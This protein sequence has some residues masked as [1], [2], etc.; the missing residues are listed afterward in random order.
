LIAQ[1]GRGES[2]A[3]SGGENGWTGSAGRTGHNF[4]LDRLMF[5]I[6]RNSEKNLAQ[7][8]EQIFARTAKF[9]PKKAYSRSFHLTPDV[10]IGKLRLLKEERRTAASSFLAQQL[11]SSQDLWGKDC[12]VSKR[13]SH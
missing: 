12:R 11:V 9:R 7:P 2:A 10:K 8:N 6:A 3:I 5:P 1:D 13:L 4:N